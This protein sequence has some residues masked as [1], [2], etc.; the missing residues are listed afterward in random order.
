MSESKDQI[1]FC[2][3]S[4]LSH[5]CGHDSHHTIAMFKL[6]A[7]EQWVPP[8]SVGMPT[9]TTFYIVKLLTCLMGDVVSGQWKRHTLI[10]RHLWSSCRSQKM[11]WRAIFGL[12]VLSLTQRREEALQIVFHGHTLI[13]M[14]WVYL[15]IYLYLTMQIPLRF[16]NFL[17]KGGTG[18]MPTCMFL[19]MNCIYNEPHKCIFSTEVMLLSQTLCPN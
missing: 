12:Q 16:T 13:I 15:F 14:I 8:T 7:F 4:I 17:C 1:S 10:L 2:S 6:P 5:V 9:F 19:V 3:R 18:Q 11:S